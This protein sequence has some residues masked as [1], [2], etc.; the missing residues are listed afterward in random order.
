M[1]HQLDPNEEDLDF[2]RPVREITRTLELLTGHSEGY[3]YF[4]WFGEKG[5]ELRSERA[6]R[7]RREVRRAAA[8]R[9][10]KWWEKHKTD[11]NSNIQKEDQNEDT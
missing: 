6:T 4:S 7:R 5:E 10:R 3:E 1:K 8:E 2:G 11:K 9:W